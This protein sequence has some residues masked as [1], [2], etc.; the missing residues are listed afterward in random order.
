M[1]V[2]GI[3]LLPRSI[4]REAEVVDAILKVYTNKGPERDDMYPSCR[5]QIDELRQQ[6]SIGGVSMS[7]RDLRDILLSISGRGLL[8][9]MEG[10]Q[11]SVPKWLYEGALVPAGY[12]SKTPKAVP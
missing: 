5:L 4:D 12:V 9:D 7:A 6:I 10:Y 3:T 8:L 2:H 1:A 11:G